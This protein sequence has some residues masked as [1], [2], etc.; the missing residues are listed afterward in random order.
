MG[1]RNRSFY[2][3]V[4]ADSRT[5]TDG[6]TIESLGWYDPRMEGVNFKLNME[7]V[8]YWQSNGAV[9]SNTVNSLVKQAR[10]LPPEA[11]A[12]VRPA[13]VEPPAAAAETNEEANPTVA[14][15]GN[16]DPPAPGA[17]PPL[18]GSSPPAAE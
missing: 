12:P 3:V 17:E 6:R 8:A 5:P 18:Q 11:M 9:F 15:G 14:E 10:S 2:R 7:R 4:V 1:N 13:A 16:D